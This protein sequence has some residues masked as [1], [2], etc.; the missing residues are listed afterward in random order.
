[1]QFQNAMIYTEKFRFEHGA[2][3]VENGRF[4]RVLGQPDPDAVDL[5]GAYVI[6]GLLDI[7]THGNS[8]ADYSDGNWDDY[9]RMARYSARNGITSIAPTT[10]TLPYE[11]LA[12]AFATAYR[13]A[14][15]RPAGCAVVRGA[16]MEGPFFSEKK[17]GAQN[18][19]YLRE[20]DFEAFSKLFAAGNGIVRIV[21]VAPE[22][23]GAAEFVRKASKQCTVSI[24][25][26][27]A[28]Y[29]DAVCAI[30]AGVTHLT[31]L[32][33][34]MPGITH[35]A[36]GP[37]IAALEDGADVELITDNV[38]IHP[39]VVR[40]TFN[41]F[42]DDHVILI[43]DSMMACGLPDGAYS[44]GGQAVTVRGPRATLTEHPDTIAGSATC[45]YDCMR[46]AVCEMGVPLESAVR[47]ATENPARS[48]GVDADYGSLAAGRY[49]N[50]V[51]ADDDLNIL[52]VVQKGKVIHDNR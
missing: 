17:K 36:P 42:G 14:D 9:V 10:L 19:A 48:I 34:A 32:Y 23:P 22:L 39:A 40:F 16:H 2:F 50:V 25:H 27:D 43:A 38:H 1:M 41:T 11:T 45:L 4:A 46:R 6:P 18:A 12:A 33:N 24:A 20:P 13:M 35:R 15:E 47:A 52:A 8:G 26:T 30:E 51:L 3:A 28:S 49:G 44:L 21:D 31:H 37:I 7:H 29:D 5:H